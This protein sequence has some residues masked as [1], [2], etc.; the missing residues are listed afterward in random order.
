MDTY[1]ALQKK[2]I[3][4]FE[5]QRTGNLMS[6]V[7]DDVNQ[8]ERFLNNV[9][10]EIIQLITLLI[11]AGWSLCM[12]SL[13]LGLIGM[14]PIPFIIWGS[15]YYQRKVAPFYKEIREGVGKLGT[16]LEK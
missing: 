11:F 13:P 5:S 16:R 4:Y 2:E 10:N 12:V 15:F 3:A 8:L 7:N 6:I 9:F 1:R 14:I